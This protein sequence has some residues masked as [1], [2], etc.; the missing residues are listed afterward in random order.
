[1]SLLDRLQGNAGGAPGGELLARMRALSGDDSPANRA[2][3]YQALLGANLLVPTSRPFDCPRDESGAATLPEG[4]PIP[5][6]TVENDAGQRAMLAFTDVAALHAWRS[7][8]D[9]LSLAAGALFSI[10]VQNDFDAVVLNIAGPD[11]GDLSRREFSMLAQG[12]LPLAEGE[13]GTQALLAAGGRVAVAPLAAPPADALLAAFRAA[14]RRNAAVETI[15]LFRL[16]VGGSHWSLAA[17]FCMRTR[18]EPERQAVFQSVGDQIHAALGDD[19]YV[20]FL[21]LDDAAFRSEVQR[22]GMRIVA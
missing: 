2:A 22:V 3:F 20:D 15:F 11:G 17:G 8:A 9:H 21:A 10:A 12:M 5:L 13:H 19:E 1:M 16:A 18:S 7:A 14:L 4:E 6:V